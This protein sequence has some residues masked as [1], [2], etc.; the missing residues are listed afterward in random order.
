MEKSE[1]VM[2]HD[3][4]TNGYDGLSKSR[5]IFMRGYDLAITDVIEAIKYNS[6]AM[7]ESIVAHWL[8]LHSP[9][10]AEYADE[11][12]DYMMSNRRDLMLDMLE[13]GDGDD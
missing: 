7:S 11:V 10:A 6:D 5:E 4:L 9:E 13:Q 3:N 2:S 8:D 1:N 12:H